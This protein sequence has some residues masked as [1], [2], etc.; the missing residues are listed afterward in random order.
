METG[1]IEVVVLGVQTG[2][3]ANVVEHVLMVFTELGRR[4]M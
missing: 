1:G 3:V 2:H 4:S